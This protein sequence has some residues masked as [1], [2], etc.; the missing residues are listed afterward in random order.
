MGCA[1]LLFAGTYPDATVVALEPATEAYA[2]LKRNAAQ[3]P[4]IRP[5]N[6]GAFDQDCTAVMYLGREASVTNSVRPNV[7]MGERQ[8]QVTLR[9]LSTFLPEHGIQHVSLLKIDTEG[10]EVAILRDVSRMLDQFDSFMIEY[11]S[12]EDRFEIDQLLHKDFILF[13]SSAE[14]PHRGTLTYVSR[15]LINEV[16]NCNEIAITSA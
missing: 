10:A 8:E 15:R 7:F 11:H 2:Y 16:T 14:L 6:V 13:A 1:S 4:Q 3:F 9:R 5:F 12:E